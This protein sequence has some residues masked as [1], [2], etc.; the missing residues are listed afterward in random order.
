[1]L[2][3]YLPNTVEMKA[4]YGQKAFCGTYSRDGTVFMSAC[5]GE[6]WWNKF[7]GGQMYIYTH[8]EKNQHFMFLGCVKTIDNKIFIYPGFQRLFIFAPAIICLM[9]SCKEK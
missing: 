4:K 2:Y 9:G 1:M 5:Q 7:E 3:S 8:N 6:R